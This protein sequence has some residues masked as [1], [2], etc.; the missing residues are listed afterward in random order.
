[1]KSMIPSR[2]VR[3]ELLWRVLETCRIEWALAKS[4]QGAVPNTT[5]LNLVSLR[6]S[7]LRLLLLLRMMVDHHVEASGGKARG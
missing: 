6:T 7:L 4:V 3:D 5:G 2:L 1:M